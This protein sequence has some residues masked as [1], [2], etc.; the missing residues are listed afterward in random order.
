M[1]MM[2]MMMTMKA[3]RPSALER[4]TQTTFLIY[5]VIYISISAPSL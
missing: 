4:W 3:I 2:M 5:L 1:M